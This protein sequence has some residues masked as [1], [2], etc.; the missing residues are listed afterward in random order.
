MNIDF[1][2]GKKTLGIDIPEDRLQGVLISTL[3]SFKTEKTQI[4]LVEEA[5]QNPIGSPRL[6]TLARG[7]QNVVLIASDHTRPVPSK[8]IIPPMLKE[9]RKG[10]PNADITILIATGCHRETSKEELVNK[11]GSEVVAQEKILVHDSSTSPM[12]KIGTLPSGG[13]C[14]INRLVI[15]AD[16]V[17]AEGFIEPHFFAGFSGSRKSILPG[18]ASRTTVLANHCSEF[19]AHP[20]ARTGILEGNPIHE[21][22]VWAARKAKLAFIVNVVINAEKEAIFAVSGDMVE[23]HAEGCKFLSSLCKVDAKPADIVISTNG[24]YPLDQNIYQAVKGMTAAEATVKQGGVIIML[25]RSNDGIGGDAFYHQM[26][27]EM[28]ITK[29]MGIF[30]S[31]DRNHTEADQWQTQIFIRLLLK[32][33]V[34]YVSE[35]PDEIVRGLHMIP[36]HSLEEALKKAEK[37]VGNDKA[38]ITAIPDGVS[39]MVIE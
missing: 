35:A 28:D 17:V 3:H 21:D 12:V 39:V 27:D 32:A 18:V 5:L 2:Y 14:I 8:A 30:L 15:D 29:T 10:N 38:T 31:R 23:A 37:I 11:F 20:K 16:L 36:A 7:K 4:E 6:S 9:I 1:P 25:A 19:I 33:Q 24:G 26:A 22:M 13:E 34:I